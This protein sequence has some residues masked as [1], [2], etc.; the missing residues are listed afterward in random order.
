MM[1][2][3]V[4]YGAVIWLIPYVSA[5]ALLPLMQTDYAFFKTIMIVVGSLVGALLTALY[6]KDVEKNFLREGLLL[7]VTWLAVNW[8]LDFAALLP[9]TKQ[10]VPRYFMEIGFSYT[11]MVWPTVVIGWLLSRKIE[12]RQ[13]DVQGL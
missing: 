1:L 11:A 6:F 8:V 3:R 9:F 5:I 2:K 12:R 7:A 10:T 4:G 13:S